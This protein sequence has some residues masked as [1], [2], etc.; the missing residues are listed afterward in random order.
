MQATTRKG[1]SKQEEKFRERGDAEMWHDVRNG[2]SSSPA[3]C[4]NICDE[5]RRARRRLDRLERTYGQCAIV[6]T[7]RSTAQAFNTAISAMCTLTE[8]CMVSIS[9]L[10]GSEQWEKQ[11]AGLSIR[12]T[13]QCGGQR[14]CA[15]PPGHSRSEAGS[16]PVRV[17]FVSNSSGSNAPRIRK[18]D[19][20][21]IFPNGAQVAGL[22]S[23]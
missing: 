3:G 13:R 6:E 20:D 15:G 21:L 10:C 18:Q 17:G 14:R 22:L 2:R 5:Y 19:E 7:A 16:S 11:Q 9:A 1:G 8:M 23:E 12:R 4:G